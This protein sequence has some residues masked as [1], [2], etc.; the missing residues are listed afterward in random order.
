MSDNKIQIGGQAVIEGVMMRGPEQIATAVRRKDGSVDILKKEFISLTKNHKFYKKPVIR[1]FVSLI[2]M[3][4]IGIQSLN[5]SANRYEID[6]EEADKVAKS[7]RREKLEEYLTIGISLILAF[8]LFGYLPY[9][10]ASLLNLGKQHILFNLFAGSLRIVFFILYIYLI[11]L[12]KDVRRVFE[13]HG[14]EH[15]SVFAHENKEPMTVES[16]KPYTTIHPRCG[17]S[18]MFFVLLVAI[19]VFSIID[20][21]V[22]VYWTVPSAIVRLLYHLPFLPVISGLSYE[23]LKLSGKKS[24]NIIIKIFTKPGMALQKITTRPPDDKQIETAII[25]LKAALNEDLSAYQN[26]NYIT[27]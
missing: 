5:F 26:I 10:L 12:M 18:F 25:A 20:T 13:Y 3:L 6:F 4:K 2:E 1:G 8:L 19:L 23:V 21:L 11:S 14:A 27:E 17:T 16:V 22:A 15:K 9:L 7:A 24:N